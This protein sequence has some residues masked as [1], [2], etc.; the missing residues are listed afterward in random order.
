MMERRVN[1]SFAQQVMLKSKI[2]FKIPSV[3]ASQGPGLQRTNQ[4]K[5]ML[6][7]LSIG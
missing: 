1:G 2:A 5:G 3:L 7:T 6:A 4:L